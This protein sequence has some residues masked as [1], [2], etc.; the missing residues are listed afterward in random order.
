LQAGAKKWLDANPV[1]WFDFFHV[2][3]YLFNNAHN[4][5]AWY[6]WQA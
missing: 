4:F 3:S 2:V 1:T 5:V 6:Y